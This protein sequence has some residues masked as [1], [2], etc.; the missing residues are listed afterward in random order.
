M[1]SEGAG[2]G[3]ETGNFVLGV[4][5]VRC[6]TVTGVVVLTSQWPAV[7]LLSTPVALQRVPFCANIIVFY[8][9]PMNAVRF[10]TGTSGYYRY[11]GSSPICP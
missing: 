6:L 1:G 11:L 3:E 4:S 9:M 8:F 10:V 5:P 7:K 2:F